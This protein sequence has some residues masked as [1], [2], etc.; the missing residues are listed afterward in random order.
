MAHGIFRPMPWHS[1][2]NGS[3][4]DE[5]H[6]L[7][8]HGEQGAVEIVTTLAGTDEDKTNSYT[9]TGLRT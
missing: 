8:M 6:I 2:R 9:P 4:P 3:S 7:L 5:L 1:L